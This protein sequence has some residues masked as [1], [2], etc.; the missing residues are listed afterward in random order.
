MGLIDFINKNLTHNRDVVGDY[1]IRFLIHVP[2][3]ILMSVPFIGWAII[4]LF[5]YYEENEDHWVSDIAFKDVAGAIAGMVIGEIAWITLIVLVLLPK[6][7][8]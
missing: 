4:P 2:M 6:L 5:I 8:T 3:G 1:G 7:S